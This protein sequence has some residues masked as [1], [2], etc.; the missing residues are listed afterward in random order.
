MATTEKTGPPAAAAAT[1]EAQIL[2]HVLING[3]LSALDD[4]QRLA[5]YERVCQSLGLNPLTKPFDYLHLGDGRGGKKLILYAKRDCTDQLRRIH[6]I[7]IT[8]LSADIHDG[9]YLV[10]AKAQDSSGRIDTS[11]GAVP[12]GGLKG[13]A[14]ANAMMKAET[15]AKRRVTLSIAGLGWLDETE[16][17]T[18]TETPA[19]A[20]AT[21]AQ[22]KRIGD[23]WTQRHHLEPWLFRVW[24]ELRY[25][26]TSGAQLTSE[27]ADDVI[28]S[29]EVTPTTMLRELA[30]K[31]H[32]E[33]KLDRAQRDAGLDGPATA[34][35]AQ[36]MFNEADVERLSQE[37]LD[38]LIAEI[39]GMAQTTVAQAKESRR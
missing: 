20:L 33:T 25:H 31:A 6:S 22:R 38:E 13:D 30:A 27:Q 28:T 26:V 36:K 4:K 5:Y 2:E 35:L 18:I 37:Q 23:L 8:E 32:H 19:A 39:E 17:E 9:I 7:S 34:R 1:S 10:R 3:D 15:K 21:D 14:L 12:I 24:L 11:T 29:L 16:T